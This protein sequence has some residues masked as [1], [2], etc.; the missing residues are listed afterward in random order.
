MAS[1]AIVKILMNL[2]FRVKPRA[3]LV[4]SRCGGGSAMTFR[5]PYRKPYS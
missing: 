1:V 3:Y 5:L 4:K 2:V